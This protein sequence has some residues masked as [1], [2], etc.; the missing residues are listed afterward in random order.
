[1]MV[2]VAFTITFLAFWGMVGNWTGAIGYLNTWEYWWYNVIYGL[3]VSPWW[4]YSQITVSRPRSYLV[5]LA[6][7][8]ML[9]PSPR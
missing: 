7:L 5:R 2:V 6:T 8:S 4:S 1:M 9:D 3:F